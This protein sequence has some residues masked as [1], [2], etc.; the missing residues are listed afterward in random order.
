MHHFDGGGEAHGTRT[1]GVE[2]VEPREEASAALESP[3]QPFDLV[4]RLVGFPVIFP[5]DFPA[6]LRRHDRRHSQVADESA[7]LVALAG[8]VHRQRRAR[9]R[10]VPA[11]RQG[12]AFGRV[13]G[14][15]VGQAKNH[16]LPTA[17]GDHVD[18]RVPSAARLADALR[19][20]R[21]PRPGAVGM[22]LGA[23]AVEAEADR[24]LADRLL[25]PERGEQPLEHAAA[26]P[27]AE[28]GVDGGPFS[29]VLRQG[30][31]FAAILQDVQDRIDEVDG[32]NP[33]IPALNREQ[34]PYFGVLFRCDLFHDCMP[35]DFYVIVYSHLS[36][37]PSKILV[38]TGP[39]RIPTRRKNAELVQGLDMLDQKGT[40]HRYRVIALTATEVFKP[41]V[42]G[43]SEREKAAETPL[44]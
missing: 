1:R 31:P 20:V 13:V 42:G 9:D 11:L 39:N 26:R 35:L 4:P 32:R 22:P 41:S 25:L 37:E 15:P 36:T 34:R 10:I 17:C 19:P 28:P 40:L 38:L 33:Y 5:F 24:V 7:G 27:A 18:L 6:R 14:L 43:L 21:L 2:L 29:E 44:T 3:E 30:A 16:C 12:A 8:A 23:G